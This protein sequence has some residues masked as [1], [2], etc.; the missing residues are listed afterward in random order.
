ME[1]GLNSNENDDKLI[2]TREKR[3]RKQKIYDDD[4]VLYDSKAANYQKINFT[5]GTTFFDPCQTGQNSA[6][7]NSTSNNDQSSTYYPTSSEL[8]K[9][10]ASDLVWA[11]VSG[12]PWWPCMIS[13]DVN[14]NNAHV[15]S[16]GSSRS[17]R[18]YFVEFFGPSVEHAWVNEGCL[19]EYKGI[20]AFKT[21]AQDEVDQ[22]P[23]KSQKEK[24]AE[25]FQ[26]KVALTRRD[27]WERAVQ[28]ADEALSKRKA[29]R[30][31]YFYDKTMLTGSILRK[32]KANTD[33]LND[34]AM[35]SDEENVIPKRI[36]PKVSR[37]SSSSATNDSAYQMNKTNMQ[38]IE[39]E[40]NKRKVTYFF[41]IIV[42]MPFI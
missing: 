21:Y 9:Y 16:I 3:I 29:E 34:V 31:Q 10:H 13:S 41:I 14:E 38:A 15:K 19:I 5:N 42:N 28:E 35:N 33:D 24:L 26:L 12:H 22:A 18:L 1:T 17:K 36:K 7:L 4:Y 32:S 40:L 23:T 39:M 11:K 2:N 37:E 20:E 6:Q 27:H 30:K 25:R 8:L